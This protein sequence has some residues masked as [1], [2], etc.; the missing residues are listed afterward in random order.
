MYELL[1][2]DLIDTHE[3]VY[4]STHSNARSHVVAIYSIHSIQRPTKLNVNDRPKL[5][6]EFH[7]MLFKFPF[8]TIIIIKCIYHN[9]YTHDAFIR[10]HPNICVIN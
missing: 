10:T 7:S 5:L 2:T 9:H 6:G 3:F 8:A 4:M 1:I